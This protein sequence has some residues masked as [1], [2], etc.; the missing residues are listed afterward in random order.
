MQATFGILW[1]LLIGDTPA[2]C[3]CVLK[4]NCVS[5]DVLRAYKN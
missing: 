3:L 5:C 1:M 4:E 2:N